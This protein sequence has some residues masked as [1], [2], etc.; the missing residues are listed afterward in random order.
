MTNNP[1]SDLAA[2]HIIDSLAVFSEYRRT[3]AVAH[4]FAGGMYWKQEGVYEYLVKTR[5]GQPQERLGR[6]DEKTEAIYLAFHQNKSSLEKR[7]VGIKGAL[8]EHERLNKAVKAGQAPS[9]LISLFNAFDAA[10][11]ADEITVVGTH[12]LYAYALAG[13]IRIEPGNPKSR[14][15]GLLWDA[16]DRVF[17]QVKG[18]QLKEL[19]PV[20][21]DV[22]LSFKTVRGQRDVAQNSRGFRVELLCNVTGE[23]SARFE[24]PVIAVNGRIAMMRTLQPRAFV[25]WIKQSSCDEQGVR[26]AEFVNSLLRERLLS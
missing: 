9:M 12:A 15:K 6:R 10:D 8:A 16:R 23:P 14:G 17:L 18:M 19:L 3:R 2:R 13:G 22:D 20:L 7:L 5:V 4:T 1:I 24:M 26:Q 11:L 21:Q 25:S